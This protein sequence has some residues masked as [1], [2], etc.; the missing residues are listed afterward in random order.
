MDGGLVISEPKLN[1]LCYQ[2]LGV[3]L[4][5][6]RSGYDIV[7]QLENIRPVKTSQVY[8]TLAR[9]E[10]QGLVLSHDVEQAGKPNKRVYSTTANGKAVHRLYCAYL[11][12]YPDAGGLAYWVS[13]AERSGS[14]RPLS[15]FFL[16][17]EEFVATYGSLSDNDFV[18]LVYG[19]VL[20]RTPDSGGLAYWQGLLQ[21]G[22]IDRGE[23]MLQFS[24]SAEFVASTGSA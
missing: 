4:R 23:L 5:K 11:Q 19:N 2:I 7:K 20:D 10:K 3:L 21:A 6:P 18:G 17:S 22:N 16:N 9:L 15:G 8:P 24:E 1:T 14:V 12:R 13:I